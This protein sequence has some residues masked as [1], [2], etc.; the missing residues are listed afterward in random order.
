MPNIYLHTYTHFY[1]HALK[2]SYFLF[3]YVYDYVQM[4]MSARGAPKRLLIT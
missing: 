4:G 2:T 1:F 3:K